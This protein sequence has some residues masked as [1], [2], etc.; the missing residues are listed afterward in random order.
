MFDIG[1]VMAK[2]PVNTV[3][4]NVIRLSIFIKKLSGKKTEIIAILMRLIF[5][6]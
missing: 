5:F 3:I 6:F 2:K 1:L 4:E